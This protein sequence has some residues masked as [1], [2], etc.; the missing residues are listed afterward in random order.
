MMLPEGLLVSTRHGDK[1]YRG[2]RDSGRFL[3]RHAQPAPSVVEGS[4]CVQLLDP[5]AR[6]TE[7]IPSQQSESR[8]KAFVVVIPKRSELKAREVE[9]PGFCACLTGHR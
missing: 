1:A 8:D 4:P 3:C 7:V 6:L 5:I 2:L 9:G